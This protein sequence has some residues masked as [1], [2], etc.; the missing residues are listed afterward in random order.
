MS[1]VKSPSAWKM[2]QV[3]SALMSAR[4]RIAQDEDLVDDATGEVLDFTKI[5]GDAEAMLH[6]TMRAAVY[7][8][9][10]EDAVKDM[11]ERL[12]VRGERWKARKEALRGAAFAAM[13]V[14]ELKRVQLPDLTATVAAGVASVMITDETALPA[15][16]LRTTVAPDKAKIKDDLKLG[17]VVPGAE[18]TNGL[19]RLQIR[20]K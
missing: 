17:V 11:A 9:S 7:A 16:Y 19:P 2:E 3:M 6:A 15:E 20:S 14:L 1:D 18:L 5:E 4:A 13:D 12:K 8:E 10:M